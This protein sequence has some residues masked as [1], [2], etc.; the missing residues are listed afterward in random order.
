[1]QWVMR[2]RIDLAREHLERSQRGVEQIAADVGLGTGANLRLHF[3]RPFRTVAIT[4]LSPA[5]AAREPE[6]GTRRDTTHD[7][8]RH[9]RI[10]PHRPQRAARAARTRQRP[11]GRRRQRPHGVRHPRAAARLLHDGGPARPSGDRR[12]GRPR[13]RR[14][15]HHRA[16][17]ARTG[18]A[19]VGRPRRRYRA[20]AT[21]R[22]TSATAA[23]AHL[24]AGARRVLI[25]APADGADVTLAF[26]VNTAAYDPAAHT[27]VS[28]ASCTTNAR[29]PLAAALDGCPGPRTRGRRRTRRRRSGRAGR[30]G[31]P[32]GPS[33]PTA[34]PGLPSR[35]PGSAAEQRSGGRGRSGS[36]SESH[37]PPAS[38]WR[39]G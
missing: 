15:S 31:W 29:A 36:P 5:D 27:I 26:G 6:G 1:M 32:R 16:R 8:Y 23:R 33:V 12:R 7:S 14:P 2:A 20:G 4:P 35:P 38:R 37:G 34:S 11:R 39:A 25:S 19:A 13:R 10:R 21:G 17:R 24:D 9:Q 22:F 18:A 28:N 30:G 3:Q